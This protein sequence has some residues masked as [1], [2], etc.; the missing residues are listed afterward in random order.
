MHKPLQPEFE[1]RTI[2]PKIEFNVL[3]SWV[4]RVKVLAATFISMLL[5]TA[6]AGTLFCQ[7]ATADFI[8]TSPATDPPIIS[9]VSPTNRTYQNEV[10]LHLNIK[11]LYIRDQVLEYIGYTLDNQEHIISRNYGEYNMNWSTTLK[12]LTEGTHSLQVTAYCRSYY[13]TSTSGGHLYYRRYANQSDI[14][15]FTVVYPPKITIL[16]LQNTTYDT[17]NIQLN[18]TVNE[19]T[20]KIKYSLDGKENVTI[21][22]NTTLTGLSNGKHNVTI[23][24]TDK[25]GH[26]GMSESLHFTIEPSPMLIIIPTAS[27]AIITIG[28]ILYFKKRKH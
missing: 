8:P 3:I 1:S 26:T 15:H 12:D 28:I 5:L 4:Q 10:L 16:T 9:V 2:K 27:A 24:A 17:N 22:G 23:Y 25:D 21:A 19:P 11:V 14:I 18:F 6:T 7:V 20:S 13:A